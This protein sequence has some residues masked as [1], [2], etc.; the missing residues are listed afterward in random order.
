MAETKIDER[1]ISGTGL[2]RLPPSESAVRYYS[3]LVDVIRLP[4][5]RFPSFK[6]SPPRQRYATMVIVRN[7]YVVGEEPIDYL[8]RRF[9]FLTNEPGQVLLALKCSHGQVLQ[10][11]SG[12][13]TPAVSVIDSFSNLNMIWSELRFVCQEFTALKVSLYQEVYDQCSDTYREKSPPPPPPPPAPDSN[14]TPIADISP[15]YEDDDDV[16]SKDPQ[17]EYFTPEPPEFPQGSNCVPYLV[18]VTATRNTG[19]TQTSSSPVYGEITNIYLGSGNT[20]LS[21]DCRGL[22]LGT[23]SP[24]SPTIVTVDTAVN[25]GGFVPGSL[26]YT[27]A[28]L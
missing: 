1:I 4:R 27:I 24:C 28:P 25:S 12:G 20:A 19:G 5:T 6:Y 18:T 21:I 2:L 16:T 14:N 8:N 26:T 22:Y 9:D 3:V 17:D 15:P 7:G 13:G 10:Q 11:L 23:S